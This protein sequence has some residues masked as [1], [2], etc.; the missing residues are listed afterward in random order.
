MK[1]TAESETLPVV[2]HWLATHASFPTR[3]LPAP[4]EAMLCVAFLA[5]AEEEEERQ[6]FLIQSRDPAQTAALRT[7]GLR[8]SQVHFKCDN[9]AKV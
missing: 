8:R 6:R 3:R 9:S 4:A 2:L 7:H 5:A 1:P